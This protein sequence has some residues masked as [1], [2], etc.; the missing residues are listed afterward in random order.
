MP[1]GGAVQIRSD[2]PPKQDN[3]AAKGA[4]PALRIGRGEPERPT[5]QWAAAESRSRYGEVP[6]RMGTSAGSRGP[7]ALGQRRRCSGSGG[8]RRRSTS[9]A[10][11]LRPGPPV[12]S[13]RRQACPLWRAPALMERGW[14][15]E[16]REDAGATGWSSRVGGCRRG[17]RGGSG[18]SWL[19]GSRA[20]SGWW[21]R[22]VGGGEGRGG[23]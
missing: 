21:L 16:G 5:P 6:T 10:G 22:Q 20:G 18:L 17:P 1:A 14:G 12:S 13:G 11:G 8:R 4:G 15:R 2:A 3:R 19:G 23:G 9:S 7:P